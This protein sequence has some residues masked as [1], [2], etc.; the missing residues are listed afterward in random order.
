MISVVN[1]NTCP[2]SM[3]KEKIKIVFQHYI[4]QE[5]ID[6]LAKLDLG[7]NTGADL[8][9]NKLRKTAYNNFTGSDLSD[10][11]IYIEKHKLE[12]AAEIGIMAGYD[13]LKAGIKVLWAGLSKL[14][15]KIL[16]AGHPDQ[17][18]DKKITLKIIE[19]DK[20]TEVSFDGIADPAESEK[21][22]DKA[23]AFLNSTQAREAFQQPKYVIKND[24]RIVHLV[25]NKLTS[26]YEPVD[27][28]KTRQAIRDM[29]KWA[30]ENLSS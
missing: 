19:A 30:D 17:N 5:L 7:A 28:E 24:K 4:P 8:E 1:F 13:L 25:Y 16:T 12:T 3:K 9:L 23:F 20:I 21:I 18:K 11:I 26:E 29:E 22:I 10:I 15:V 2:P 14:A 6:D 27:F